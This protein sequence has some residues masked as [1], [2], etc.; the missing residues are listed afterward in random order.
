M[1]LVSSNKTLLTSSG[2]SYITNVESTEPLTPLSMFSIVSSDFKNKANYLH[3]TTVPC[4]NY[5]CLLS[6]SVLHQRLG[7]PSSHVLNHVIK[8]CPSVKTINE[9]RTFDSCDACK[10]G[11]MHRL[12]FYVTNTKTKFPLEI[13]HT[14]L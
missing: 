10:M 5:E 2:H 7:H 6:T 13:L 1:L 9:N 4:I 12:H 8:T 14:D 3:T 11:K